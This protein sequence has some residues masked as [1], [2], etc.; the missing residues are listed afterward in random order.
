MYER[1]FGIKGPPF[2]LSPDPFFFFD[3]DQH[4]A[5]LTAM[6]QAFSRELPFVVLT[7]EIGAGKTT[8]LRVW[9]AEA[10]AAGVTVAQLANTQ[11]DAE[12]LMRAVAIAFGT[13]APAGSSAG[14]AAGLGRFL[15][16]LKGRAAL[17]VI[18][19]AQNLERPA[20]ECLVGL[21]DLAARQ[22]AELRICLA[23]QP[24]LRAHLAD[25]TFPAVQSRV[26]QS[27]HLGPLEPAQTRPYIEHRL[28]KVGWSG[29][30]SFD[31]AAFEEIHRFTGGVPRRINVL[32]NRLMLSQFLSCTAQI[33]AR[34]VIATA[35]ALDAEIGEA[36]VVHEP[37]QTALEALHI[38]AIA[39]GALLLVASGRSDHIK[40][41]PLVRA[42]GSRRD[43]PPPVIV[44]V[45]DGSAWRLNRDLHAFVGL[46]QQPVSLVDDAQPMLDQVE[47]RFE[48]LV[49]QCRP[50]AVIVIDGDPVSQCC[51]TVARRQGVP[52]V[53]VD[54]DAQGAEEFTDPLSARAAIGRLAD[55]RFDCQC[56]QQGDGFT[57]AAWSI[58]VGNP[59]ID[60]VSLALQMAQSPRRADQRRSPR[61]RMDDR[62]GYG[63]VAL[64]QL[65]ADARSPC[66]QEVVAVLRD[67][68]RDLPLVWPMRRATMLA[69]HGSGLA[70][71]LAH[72][73]IACIEELGHAGF[74]RLLR[75][76]TCVLT[77]CLDVLEEA[78]V[79]RVPC[80]S[81]GARHAGHVD[82][83]GWLPGIEVGSSVTRATRAVWEVV[84]N[85]GESVAPPALWDGHAATRIAAH[86]A[87]WLAESRE[88]AGALV[89]DTIQ[90]LDEGIAPSHRA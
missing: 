35:H 13:A 72:D 64:K 15:R 4:H 34:A 51:A 62:R 19:E 37:P 18:D 25:P 52:L 31:A 58:G 23:G 78:A 68:S 11:L 20:L 75:D 56:P 3:S 74:V 14:P 61:E 69:M 67:V 21:A 2:Q 88:G 87:R 48:R 42:M 36:A 12:E 54:A 41:V 49:E 57:R 89:F 1:H 33:D 53:H 47:A 65:R 81:L 16:E 66:R 71:T 60:A 44:S 83:G 80:L 70:R 7:G 90:P 73:R 5:A 9:I 32:G 38:A 22:N 29:T 84:F 24:E 8:I 45:S 6:R 39:R 27:C 28:L 76:T 43:L 85:G 77:D 82:A 46:A 26:Q 10:E 50:G 17:L 63:V 79:L 40:A 55:L 59:L 30:P 86:L